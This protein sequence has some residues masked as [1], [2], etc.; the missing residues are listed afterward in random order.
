MNN[1]KT[2]KQ[3]TRAA[4]VA[5]LLAVCVVPAAAEVEIT[6]EGYCWYA[7]AVDAVG[8]TMQVLGVANAPV[9]APPPI[10]MDFDTYQY[11]VW[12]DEMV[13]AAFNYDMVDQ[14]KVTDFNGGV[15]RIYRQMKAGG[16]PADYAVPATFT[17]GELILTATVQ[18]GWRMQLSDPFGM[19]FAGS[20]I[21]LCDFDGGSSL[22][23]LIEFGGQPFLE[24]WTFAGTGISDPSFFVTV[25]DGYDRIFGIKLVY[26][27]PVP[28]GESSWGG[29]KALF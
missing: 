28:A 16:T 20:G 14:K 24:N 5:V 22:A 27:E 15:I 29:V 8:S 11:T 19:T 23:E 17:D 1:D 10:V 25:P 4:L 12:V 3:L 13:V 2:I 21:G 26:P 9:S 7:P 6:F 18:D